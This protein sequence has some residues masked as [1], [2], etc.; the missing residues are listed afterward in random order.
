VL[1]YLQ[2]KIPLIL[3]HPHIIKLQILRHRGHSPYLF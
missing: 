2:V 3:L 1:S